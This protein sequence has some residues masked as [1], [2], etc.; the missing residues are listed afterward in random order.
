MQIP[1]VQLI[2]LLAD[3][4]SVFFSSF[5]LPSQMFPVICHT[6]RAPPSPLSAAATRQMLPVTLRDAQAR[7]ALSSLSGPAC[8]AR[9]QTVVIINCALLRGLLPA[10]SASAQLFKGSLHC[11]PLPATALQRE[12]EMCA[13]E[14]GL[15]AKDRTQEEG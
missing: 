7:P 13:R 9:R 2:R 5:A 8:S 14:T 11:R 6:S 15:I 12:R 4:F 10:L 3:H 1:C